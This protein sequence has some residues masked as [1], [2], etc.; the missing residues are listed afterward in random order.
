MDSQVLCSIPRNLDGLSPCTHEDADTRLLLHAAD[1]AQYGHKKVMLR[2]VDTNVVVLST[3]I[4][5]D[6]AID[7][8]WISCG[9]DKSW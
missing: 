2:T 4:F 9:M 5:K 1:C 7:E 6:L 3:A 8:M